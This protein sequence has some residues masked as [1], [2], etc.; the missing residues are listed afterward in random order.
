MRRATPG[1]LSIKLIAV[2]A[3]ETEDSFT[4]TL[5]VEDGNMA[6]PWR[7]EYFAEHNPQHDLSEVA[8]LIHRAMASKASELG[9]PPVAVSVV[10][11]GNLAT[12]VVARGERGFAA[13]RLGGTVQGK[14]LASCDD[15]SSVDVIVDASASP[16]DEPLAILPSIAL[17]AHEYGHAMLGR[18]RSAV[19]TRPARPAVPG[20]QTTD[21]ASRIWAFLSADEFRCDA[22]ADS[23]LSGVS[24][25]IDGQ[26][27][28]PLKLGFLWGDGYRDALHSALDR[29]VHPG[30][31]DLVERYQFH[32]MR[33]ED[34]YADI[35]EQ[36]ES[37]LKLLA[38]ADATDH[39]LDKP[40]VLDQFDTHPGV[41]LYLKEAWQ[42]IRKILLNTDPI[43]SFDEFADVDL[44]TQD[45]GQA[46]ADMW[47][48]L[49]ISSFIRPD[50]ELF[51][52]VDTP[53]R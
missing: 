45:A 50:G 38:H 7:F 23:V 19:K 27:P 35:F 36:T 28:M 34:M 22:L 43:P 20:G 8:E 44:A 49:G 21:E 1:R 32:Q 18:M 47:Q 24:I 26:E 4:V 15:W 16:E 6:E 52:R 33:L 2:H 29:I 14:T 42:P 5:P 48:R 3:C 12:S 41:R 39:S 30:W 25:G 13:E 17:L 11:S 37:V 40:C 51:V 53:V 46:I 10:A 9:I 31:P